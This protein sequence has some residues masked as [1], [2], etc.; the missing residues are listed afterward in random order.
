MTQAMTQ[1]LSP[2]RARDVG[3]LEGGPLHTIK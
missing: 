1:G 3:F 2:R